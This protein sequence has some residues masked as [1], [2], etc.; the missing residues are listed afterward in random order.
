[1]T[2]T[3]EP[4][5][6]DPPPEGTARQPDGP[7]TVDF[8]GLYHAHFR[9][10]TIQLT[11]YCGDL[12]QAQDMVQEAFCRAFARWSRVSRYEDPV[13]WV[14][15]VAWNLTTSRWRRART[16]RAWLHR[17]REEYVPG[18]G[19]DRVALTAAL[20]GLPANQRRAVVLHYLAD[21]S[22][23]QIAVQENVPEGTVKS[24]LHRGRAAL[25]AQLTPTNEVNHHD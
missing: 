13:A 15:R 6:D 18:P 10:L 11:A 14:R 1:M 21:L 25:A 16:A 24:W 2:V 7:T 20:A 4:Q 17:Q 5:L 8:D 23:A 9:S 3:R 19:P 22:V 12:A